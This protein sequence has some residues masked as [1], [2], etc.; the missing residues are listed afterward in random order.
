MNLILNQKSGLVV[1]VKRARKSHSSQQQRYYRKW[2]GEFAK[3]IGYTHDEMHEEILCRTFGTEH[4]ETKMGNIRRPMKRSSEI[5]VEE[6]GY[7]IDM[8]I[9][10]AAELDYVVPPPI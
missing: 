9:L 1:E 3:F 8:L 7:L 6:Y 5:G 10:T 2:L 4:V